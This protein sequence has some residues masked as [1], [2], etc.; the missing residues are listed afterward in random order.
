MKNHNTFRQKENGQHLLAE[1]SIQPLAGLL[2]RAEVARRLGVCVHTVARNKQL[3]P[4]KF[5]ARLVRYRIEDVEQF[6]QS[7]TARGKV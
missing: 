3:T 5:N 7:A 2:S 1:A 6:I 4:I